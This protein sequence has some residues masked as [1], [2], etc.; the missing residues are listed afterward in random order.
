M[1]V[2][3]RSSKFGFCS[4][5]TAQPAPVLKLC[6]YKQLQSGVVKGSGR[7][8][9]F[10]VSCYQTRAP[11]FAALTLEI[12][13]VV[14]QFVCETYVISLVGLL[15]SSK[16][17][18]EFSLYRTTD[19]R[20]LG[21]KLQV[22]KKHRLGRS[23]LVDWSC[24]K[25]GAH[26]Q[27]LSGLLARNHVG[28]VICLESCRDLFVL[29]N[30]LCSSELKYVTCCKPSTIFMLYS[31]TDSQT[32]DINV[33]CWPLVESSDSVGSR[34]TAQCALVLKLCSFKRW[35]FVLH[36]SCY[37]AHA[38][39][40]ATSTLKIR[41]SRNSVCLWNLWIALWFDCWYRRKFGMSSCSIAQPINV[42]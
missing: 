15:I 12:R 33:C 36:I 22:S 19:Q 37:H 7:R 5:S 27:W 9:G 25:F 34:S 40:L 39:R 17:R 29:L 10:N 1:Y 42:L 2:V 18:N 35:R 32:G 20:A 8:F 28:L 13:R 21:L 3:C 11:R 31:S 14:I 30:R 16:V 4:H 23:S 24:E 38:P 6:S 26:V 41:R